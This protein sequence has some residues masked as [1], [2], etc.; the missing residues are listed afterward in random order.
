MKNK[1][2]VL[3]PF[4]FMLV[5]TLY[6]A[7]PTL[8]EPNET[9]AFSCV[10][11]KPKKIVS[12]CTSRRLTESTGYVQYRFGLPGKIELV[13]PGKRDGSQDRFVY[14]RYTRPMVTRIS[15]SFKNNGYDYEVY[16]DQ[17]HEE[18]FD[19]VDF[20]ELSVSGN[21]MYCAPNAVGSLM[22]LEDVLPN[23]PDGW[24]H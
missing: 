10:L 2:F 6:A 5:S 24:M 4:L 13:F 20:I 16:S 8:C 11:K 9:V 7:T 12:I 19:P 3:A 1:L 15:L 22:S 21:N 23:D 18:G 14:S 17:E